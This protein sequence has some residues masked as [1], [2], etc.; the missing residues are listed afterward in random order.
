MVI[1]ADELRGDGDRKLGAGLAFLEGGSSLLGEVRSGRPRPPSPSVLV[2]IL[3]EFVGEIRG[4]RVLATVGE[5]SDAEEGG[6]AM[7]PIRVE[8]LV[9]E[10][11]VAARRGD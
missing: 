9:E 1:E 4:K 2:V 3:G 8:R 11:F 10:R 6:R 7:L 5:A